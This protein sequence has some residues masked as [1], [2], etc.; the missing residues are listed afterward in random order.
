MSWTRIQM[1]FGLVLVLATSGFVVATTYVPTDLGDLPG[2]DDESFGNAIN[3]SGQI[4]GYGNIAADRH[5]FFWSNGVM[6]DLGHLPGG[7]DYSKARGINASGQVVGVSDISGARGFLWSNGVMT[8][9]GYLNVLD[10]GYSSAYAINDSGQVVGYSTDDAFDRYPFLWQNGVMTSLGKLPGASTEVDAGAA[11]YG[12]NSSGQVVGYC[13]FPDGPHA[14]LWEN[15]TM[16]ALAALPGGD[17]TG[18]ALAINASG[19][20][21]GYSGGPT[22]D[23]PVLWENGTI[24]DLGAPSG[25]DWDGWAYGINTPGQVVGRSGPVGFIWDPVNG[26]RDLNAMLPAGLAADWNI[27]RAHGINDAGQIVAEGRGPSGRDHAILLTPI[28]API[29]ADIVGGTGQTGQAYTQT[30]TLAG[31]D[32]ADEW[33]LVAGPNDLTVN[34]NTGVVSWTPSTAVGSPFS[35]TIRATNIDGSDDETWPI[36]VTSTVEAPV[37]A[38]IPDGTAAV[39]QAYTLT[40][41]LAQ[42]DPVDTWDLIAGP[43]DAMIDSSSGRV[44]WPTPTTA[45]SPVT[46]TIRATNIGGTDDETWELGVIDPAAAAGPCAASAP[47]VVLPFLAGLLL[48]RRGGS[49]RR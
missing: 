7:R 31:G 43:A 14:F 23:R 33:E 27:D 47:M 16:T 3:A 28:E 48:L 12:I 26:M 10:T 34:P 18:E 25:K 9:L 32:P 15:G 1:A 40:P 39:G 45:G 29:I 17:G 2:G 4:A 8:D 37:I 13:E 24:T 35:V 22:D 36:T 46:M 5:G 19:K 11:G 30:P 42:G 6:T 44:T 49:K 21:V 38:D 41:S 20:V